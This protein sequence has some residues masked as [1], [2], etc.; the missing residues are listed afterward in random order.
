MR[1]VTGTTPLIALD[2]VAIDTETTG[3]DTARARIVQIGGIGIAAGRLVPDPTLE[4]L[5]APDVAIPSASSDIHGVTDAMV[6]DAPDFA[7]AWAEL[8]A[9][10][11]GR[12]LIGHSIGFDLA[13]LERE[14]RRAGLAWK[15]PRSLCVRLLAAAAEPNLPDYSLETLADWLDISIAGRHSALGDA[16]AAA[17]IFLALLPKLHD[18][19]IRTLAEAERACLSQTTELDSA[20]RAGWIDPVSTPTAPAYQSVDPY[21]YRHRVGELMSHPPIVVRS[22]AVAREVVSL[23]VERKISSVFVSD[24]GKAERPVDAYGIV[25]ERDMMRRI[26]IDGE[27]AL[28]VRIGEMA[29]SPLVSIRAQAF[30]YRAIG[31]MNRLGIRHLAVRDE[32]NKLVGI[33]SARD[34]LRLRGSA[35]INLDDAIEASGSVAEMAAAWA[36]LPTVTDALIAEGV[37][38]HVICE[39]ISEELRA[40]TRRAAILAEA[41]MQ[42]EG[43]GPPPCPYALLVLGSGGRGESLLAADQDNSIVFAEGDPGGPNDRWFAMLGARIADMLDASG[44]PYCKGGVM[45]KNAEFRGSTALWKSRVDEWIRRSRPEDLLN[46]DIFFD[47]RPIYGDLAMGTELF[48]YAHE[49]GQQSAGFA[50]LLGE[51]MGEIPSAFTLL[52]GFKLEGGRLDLK[53]HGLFPV[54]A[55]ARTLAIRH[56]IRAHSTRDRLEGLAK[57]DIGGDTDFDAMRSGHSFLLSMLL[58]QQ[59]R[60]LHSGHPVSNK[61]ELGRF[62]K[63]EQAELK[64]VLKPLQSAPDLVRDLMFG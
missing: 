8:L 32:R 45:A 27:H 47:L 39:I 30:A 35:A 19:N 60:D 12:I 21:A 41:A 34:L 23:M 13:V 43:H 54:V 38:A 15:K 26:A 52:G 49:R 5:V 1:R 29:T 36:T 61:V 59:S 17:N 51:Q 22:S 24:S 11:H 55:T 31:R 10:A 2:A 64:S 42:E 6:R 62:G 56:G 40:M 48:D 16:T 44:I 14:V 25:T 57:L 28:D 9:F 4:T 53:M 33:V 46:V 63:A 3:L 37:D 50:K 7:T 58:Q 18:R 20:R